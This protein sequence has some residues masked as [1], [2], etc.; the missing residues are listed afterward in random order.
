MGFNFRIGVVGIFGWCMCAWV[1]R[2]VP[3]LFFFHGN[4]WITWIQ[5]YMV[6]W[7]YFMHWCGGVYVLWNYCYAYCGGVFLAICNSHVLHVESVW[8]C[9]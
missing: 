4:A 3:F 9:L 5:G 6:S 2:F 8:L 7:L 1:Q